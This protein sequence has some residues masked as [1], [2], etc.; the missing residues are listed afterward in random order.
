MNNL[1]VEEGKK[2]KINEELLQKWKQISDSYS[3]RKLTNSDNYCLEV[4]VLPMTYV[5]GSPDKMVS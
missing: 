5:M 2:L 4:N 3:S 1:L